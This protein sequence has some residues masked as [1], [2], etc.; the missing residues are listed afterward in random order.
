MSPAQAALDEYTPKNFKTRPKLE[1]LAKTLLRSLLGLVNY[2]S[3]F[4]PD[5][6]TITAPLRELTR[7]NARWQWNSRHQQALDEIKRNLTSRSVMA[8]FDPNKQTEVIVD[9]GPGGLGAILAQKQ[10]EVNQFKVVAY[11]SREHSPTLKLGTQTEKEAL[12]IV[13]G[14]EKFHTYLYGTTFD[15]I[16]DH[17]PLELIF[18][19]PNSKPPARIER[20]GLHLQEYSFNVKYRPGACNPADFMSGH[21]WEPSANEEQKLTEQYVN[22]L[23]TRAVPKAMNL[24]EIIEETNQDETLQTVKKLI[25]SGKWYEIGRTITVENLE[26][27]KSLAKVKTELTVTL[28]GLVLRGSRV[29]IPFKLQNRVVTLAH[30]GHQGMSKTKSLLREKNKLVERQLGQCIPCLAATPKNSKEPLK[31]SKLPDGPWEKVDIDFCGPMPTGEYLIVLVDEYSRFPIVEIVRSITAKTVLAKL[32][33]IFA[34][35]TRSE[36]R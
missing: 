1:I 4:I 35:S 17:K 31:M 6:A 8:Y 5:Y 30:E 24:Q 29:V 36:V 10:S 18:N 15:L 3:R 7:K 33:K 27:L 2:V 19:N 23:T 32:D 20:W 9:A 14:C 13:W 26:D 11:A 34:Y 25:Q 16:T 21:P 22:F 28:Q 12:A